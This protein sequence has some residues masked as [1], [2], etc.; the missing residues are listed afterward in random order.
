MGTTGRRSAIESA[1]F[2]SSSGRVQNG[3][4]MLAGGIGLAVIAIGLFV[5]VLFRDIDQLTMH[6]ITTMPMVMAVGLITG[7]WALIRTPLRVTV[8]RNGV[9]VEDRRG[10]TMYA[11]SD[12][13]WTANGV[14]M[15]QQPFLAIYDRSGKKLTSLGSGFRDFERMASMIRSQVAE[16]ADDTSER[17]QLKKA[18]RS[19]VLMGVGGTLLL[20]GCGV[21]GWTVWDTQRSMALLESAAVE[22]TATVDEL[23]VAPNGTTKRMRYTVTSDIGETGS[24]NVELESNYYDE[25]ED[26]GEKSVPVLFVPAEPSIS[27][28]LQGE[29]E[30]DDI[31]KQPLVGYGMSCVGMM[32]TLFLYSAGALHWR[33]WDL[34]IDS[35]TGKVSIKQ[36]GEGE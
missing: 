17:I 13:G 2:E 36:F 21:V 3:Y 32:M 8:D 7:G 19:A 34:D 1:E 29:V 27:R 6:A 24:R 20:A 9:E 16:R 10:C 12:I 4:W 31:T 15:Q 25:L 18:R 11:W 22:G 14:N 33:G 23:F 30:D 35:K 26:S 28:L 5:A